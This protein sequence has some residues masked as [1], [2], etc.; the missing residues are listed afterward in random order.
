M[1]KS[2]YDYKLCLYKFKPIFHIYS[3]LHRLLR[4]FIRIIIHIMHL[5]FFCFDG[6]IFLDIYCIYSF[7]LFSE[8]RL[9]FE[10]F[11]MLLCRLPFSFLGLFFFFF[12]FFCFSTISCVNENALIFKDICNNPYNVFLTISGVGFNSGDTT[13]DV[14]LSFTIGKLVFSKAISLFLFL[15]ILFLVFWI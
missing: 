3:Y 7:Q 14:K 2:F 11:F 12:V 6:T 9:S 10:N 5:Y 4:Q 13:I 8:G 1:I 15:H